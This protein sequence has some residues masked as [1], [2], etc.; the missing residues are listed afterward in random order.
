[1]PIKCFME[2]INFYHN[3]LKL[4]VMLKLLALGLDVLEGPSYLNRLQYFTICQPKN[5]LTCNASHQPNNHGSFKCW[6]CNKTFAKKLLAEP[7]CLSLHHASSLS[8]LSQTVWIYPFWM[9]LVSELSGK[10]CGSETIAFKFFV[11]I[12]SISAAQRSF[13]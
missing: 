1:M 6:Y 7:P 3:L 5:A 12:I 2:F 13:D 10:R 4:T 9:F 11:I 8:S